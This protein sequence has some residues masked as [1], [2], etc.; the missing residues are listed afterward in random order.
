MPRG[1]GL[2]KIRISFKSV[3]SMTLGQVFGTKP[4]GVPDIMKLIWKL[5]KKKNLRKEK[6]KE[7]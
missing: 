3:K 1:G 4:I 5:I 7:E 2:A 6:K